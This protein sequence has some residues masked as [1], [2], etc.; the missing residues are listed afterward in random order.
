V[1]AKRLLPI[2]AAAATSHQRLNYQM[3]AEEL[4]RPK[5]NARTVAQVCDLLD[6]AAALANVPLLALTTVLDSSNLHV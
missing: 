4:G 1:D 5:N 2:L 3:A 6:A